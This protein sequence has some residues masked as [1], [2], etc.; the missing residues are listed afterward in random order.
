MANMYILLVSQKSAEMLWYL[1]LG[2]MLLRKPSLFSCKKFRKSLENKKSE[3]IMPIIEKQKIPQTQQQ[4]H[5][6]V[7]LMLFHIFWLRC[8]IKQLSL[9]FS[10]LEECN[11]AWTEQLQGEC[12][13]NLSQNMS[14]SMRAQIRANAL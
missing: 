5:T 7:Y 3:A 9:P 2:C 10:T 13:C 1:T 12:L 6:S 4:N 8:C 14:R 11:T